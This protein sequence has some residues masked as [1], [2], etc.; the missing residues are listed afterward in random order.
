MAHAA[1]Q[2]YNCEKLAVCVLSDDHFGS[3]TPQLASPSGFSCL[4]ETRFVLQN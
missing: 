2:L 4:G 1:A 3:V